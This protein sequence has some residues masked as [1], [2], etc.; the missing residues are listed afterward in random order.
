MLTRVTDVRHQDVSRTTQLDG[1]TLRAAVEDDIP[2]DDFR[3]GS[4]RRFDSHAQ[5]AANAPGTEGG[6]FKC[7]QRV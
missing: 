1:G 7:P 3:S 6:A 2:M 4:N 5:L